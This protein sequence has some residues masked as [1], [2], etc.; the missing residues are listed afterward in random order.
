MQERKLENYFKMCPNLTAELNDVSTHIQFTKLILALTSI[1]FLLSYVSIL[2]FFQLFSGGQWAGFGFHSFHRGCQPISVAQLVGS[3]IL[4]NAFGIGIGFAIWHIARRGPMSHR[5]QAFQER[6]KRS[7]DG[8]SL[9]VLFSR[10]VVF[11][12]KCWSLRFHFV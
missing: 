10:V 4:L 7:H 9:R 5:S 3:A 6:Q 12:P 11:R 8:Y 1:K 2:T